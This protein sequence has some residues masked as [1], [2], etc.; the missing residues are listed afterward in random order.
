[1]ANKPEVQKFYDDIKKL[2][3]SFYNCNEQSQWDELKTQLTTTLEE[4]KKVL[5]PDFYKQY[6]DGVVQSIAKIYTYKQK[7]WEKKK[8]FTP[9]KTYLLQDELA[10]ALTAYIKLKT[11]I[12]AYEYE[13]RLN[14]EKEKNF[15]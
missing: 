4:G 11:Q 5:T 14:I 1:M 2:K 15:C 10:E 7:M 12:L 13:G 8:Q 3:D 6:R 9:K